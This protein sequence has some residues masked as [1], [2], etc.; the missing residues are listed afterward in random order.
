MFVGDSTFDLILRTLILGPMALVWVLLVVRLIG[1]RSYSKM[2]AIDFVV[3]VAH[4]SLLATATTATQWAPFLQACG[5]MAVLLATQAAFTAARRKFRSVKALE[6]TPVMLMRD[7]QF[8]RDAMVRNRIAENDV[9][10]KLREANVLRPSDAR[11]VVLETTG[12]ISV[13]HGGNID[14]ELLTGVA[15]NRASQSRA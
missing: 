13:L 15:M 6:N 12:D 5:A 2:A 7:G 9:W 1:L 14:D 3:T 4:G 11:A 10:A 8:D